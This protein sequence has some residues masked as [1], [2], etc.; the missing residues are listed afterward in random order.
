MQVSHIAFIVVIHVFIQPFIYSSFIYYSMPKW[1]FTKGCYLEIFTKHG[2]ADRGTEM[3]QLCVC[4]G[5]CVYRS[6]MK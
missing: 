6:G 3:F 1:A 2:F 4:R 5:V